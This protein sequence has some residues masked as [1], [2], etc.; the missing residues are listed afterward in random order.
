M[1]N[2]IRVLSRRHVPPA[3]QHVLHVDNLRRMMNRYRYRVKIIHKQNRSIQNY[4]FDL[5][6][7][8]CFLEVSFSTKMPN[9]AMTELNL[10]SASSNLIT[11]F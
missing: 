1:V 10:S 6:P 7:S 9:D 5:I 8:T 3:L 11:K 2:K 4:T